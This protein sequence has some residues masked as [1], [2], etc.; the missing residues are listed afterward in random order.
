MTLSPI[1]PVCLVLTVEVL[2]CHPDLGRS[3]DN[4][5]D[6]FASSEQRHSAESEM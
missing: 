5:S 2:V 1:S 6:S 4:C 3:K